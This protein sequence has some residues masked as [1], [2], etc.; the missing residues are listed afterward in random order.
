MVLALVFAF[1][2]C[3]SDD[4]TPDTTKA[5]DTTASLA[6]GTTADGTTADGTTA[7]AAQGTGLITD[8][9]LVVGMECAYAPYN[10]TQTDNSNG[11]VAIKGTGNFAYGYDV[12]MAKYL[13]EKMNCEVQIKAVDWNGLPLALQSGDID[14]VIAGQS[15]TAKREQTVD[16]TTPYYY[17]SIVC[18]AR[19]DG[20]YA[21]ADGL[22]KLDG[23]SAVSQLNT[24][25][26]NI[27][28]PQIPNVKAQP[29]MEGATQM[30]V[31]LTSGAVDIVVTDQPTALAAVAA[32]SELVMLD[33][34]GTSDAFVVSEEEVNIGI[35]VKEGNSTLLTKLN[36]G[37]ATLTDADFIRMMNEAI[38][39]QPLSE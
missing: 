17:A 23:A 9:I 37:L 2:A 10:W 16:F 4:K 6:D 26:D 33:F 25:W 15:I 24:I 3:G 14:C 36:E 13:A 7:A 8:G 5:D 28:L 22:S 39:V 18:L 34:T 21:S 12:M 20:K 29:G 27:C 35:S 31:A 1:A 30:I 19:A 38:A 11:A 32:N